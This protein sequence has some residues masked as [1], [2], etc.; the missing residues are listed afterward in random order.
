VVPGWNDSGLQE[1]LARVRTQLPPWPQLD[2]ADAAGAHEHVDRQAG[3][4]L[5]YMRARDFAALHHTEPHR[6]LTLH[7]ALDAGAPPLQIME[8]AVGGNTDETGARLCP[9]AGVVWSKPLLFVL[10]RE[11]DGYQ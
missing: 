9:A 5:G 8:V 4:R 11:Y 10:D 2:A 1:A 7:D 3:E 6:L